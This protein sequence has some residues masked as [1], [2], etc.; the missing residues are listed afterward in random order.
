[1]GIHYNPLDGSWYAPNGTVFAI[2]Y[3]KDYSASEKYEDGEKFTDSRLKASLYAMRFGF[4][5]DIGSVRTQGSIIQP[6]GSVGVDRNIMSPVFNAIGQPVDKNGDPTG[7]PAA[8]LYTQSSLHFSSTG[9][10][11][12]EL[13]YIVAPLMWGEGMKNGYLNFVLSVFVPTGQYDAKSPVNLGNNRFTFRPMVGV[14]QLVA[15]FHFDVL[16]GIDYHMDNDDYT[17]AGNA[18]LVSGNTLEQDME[19]FA[20]IHVTMFLSAETRSYISASFGGVWGGKQTAKKDGNSTVVQGE[21]ETYTASV[22]IGT[23]LARHFGIYGYYA[24]DLSAKNGFKGNEFGLRLGLVR[25]PN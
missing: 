9:L 23:Q 21:L 8:M 17:Y 7:N 6:F 5:Q 24:Q 1:M 10:A 2:M 18:G 16:F 11:D 14:G 3:T 4:F 13:N 15:P 25:L 22:T 19:T 20:E 12:T